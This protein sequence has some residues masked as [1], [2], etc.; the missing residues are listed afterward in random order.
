MNQTPQVAKEW[1]ANI[2][3]SAA[4]RTTRLS[5]YWLEAAAHGQASK[6]WHDLLMA[7]HDM[8]DVGILRA[9]NSLISFGHTSGFDALTGFILASVKLLK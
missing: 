7:L 6:P 8:D 2:Y 3:Q 4:P 9:A 5:A 1:S